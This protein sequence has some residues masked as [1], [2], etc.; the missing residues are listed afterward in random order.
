MINK[1][2]D[3]VDES[4]AVLQEIELPKYFPK[5]KLFIKRIDL[6][7]PQ[8]S[9]NKW[10]KLKYNLLYAQSMGVKTILTF[11]GAYSN[12]IYATA[13]AGNILGINTIGIIRGEEHLPLN[14]TLSF[15]SEKGMRIVYKDRQKFTEIHTGLYYEDIKNEFGNVYLLPEGGSNE[16]AVKGCAEIVHK[17]GVDF[18]FLCAP[19]G[20]GATT[21]GLIAGTNSNKSIIGF[22]ALKGEFLNDYVSNLLL[23]STGE[24]FDNWSI[25]TDYHFGGYAKLKPDLIEFTKE[26][27]RTYNIQLDYIYTAKM[28]YGLFDLIKKGYFDSNKTIISL[29]TGGLQGN[30]GMI[31]S[32]KTIIDYQ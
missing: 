30:E 28:M 15:A 1:I 20:T 32:G 5:V 2:D 9:G 17:I 18:D 25:N 3:L 16:L 11:G 27:Y 24:Y 6:I 10:Y 31:K 21:A 4:K 23:K 26:F 19:C 13:A 7:H 8:I 14:S 29:H 12:H 22:S